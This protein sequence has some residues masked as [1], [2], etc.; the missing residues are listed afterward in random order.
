MLVLGKDEYL[1]YH[2]LFFNHCIMVG[3]EE[4]LQ[5]LFIGADHCLLHLLY[6]FCILPLCLGLALLH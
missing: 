3:K 4:A 2:G 5:P 6:L 1:L